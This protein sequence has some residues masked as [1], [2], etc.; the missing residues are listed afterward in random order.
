MEIGGKTLRERIAATM[1]SPQWGTWNNQM[2]AKRLEEHIQ[3]YHEKA[4][5]KTLDK[6]PVIKKSIKDA[7]DKERAARSVKAEGS[8]CRPRRCCGA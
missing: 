4:E 8:R 3:Q 5:Q 2:R 6:F 7:E 1:A